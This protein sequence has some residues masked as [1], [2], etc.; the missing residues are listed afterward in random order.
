MIEFLKKIRYSPKSRFMLLGAVLIIA[1]GIYAIF[2]DY[3]LFK[4]FSLEYR[5]ATLEKEISGQIRIKDSLN[6][7]R[8]MLRYDTLTIERVA[9][10]KFGMVKEGEEI[11]YINGEE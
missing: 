7:R 4:R 11:Y 6:Y 2:S 8:K 3:G 5:K 10:E 9:R 1:L